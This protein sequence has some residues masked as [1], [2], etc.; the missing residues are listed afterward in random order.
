MQRQ[1]SNFRPRRP[2]L[3]S[4][5]LR[6]ANDA[7]DERTSRSLRGPLYSTPYHYLWE[8]IKTW[9]V[10]RQAKILSQLISKLPTNERARPT[11]AA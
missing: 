9:N 2:S 11:A 4:C 5:L 1:N 6:H 7:I 8:K 3:S 10:Y